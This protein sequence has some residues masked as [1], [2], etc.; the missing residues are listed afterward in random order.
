MA[1]DT[2]SR[3][4]WWLVLRR[5]GY[6][7]I[8]IRLPLSWV[9]DGSELDAVVDPLLL[10]EYDWEFYDDVSAL[11]TAETD[12]IVRFEFVAVTQGFEGTLTEIS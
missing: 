4:Q 9:P 1:S 5:T 12:L 8:R 11:P 10:N 7:T 6:R 3:R 2:T